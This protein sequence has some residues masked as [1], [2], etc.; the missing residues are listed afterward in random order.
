MSV[1][2]SGFPRRGAATTD[3]GEKTYYLLRVFTKNCMKMKEIVVV[4]VVVGGGGGW[5]P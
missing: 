4:V 3:F 1:A 5:C 2:D